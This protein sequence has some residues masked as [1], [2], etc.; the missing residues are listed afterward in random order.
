MKYFL[1]FFFTFNVFAKIELTLLPMDSIV[2]QGEIV[3]TRIQIKDYDGAISLNGVT[4]A[5]T[6]Y[7]YKMSPFIR[8]PEN[9]SM[10][11]EGSIIFLKVPK[12]NEVSGPLQN[13][14]VLVTWK[15]L[16]IQPVQ[17]PESFL[18]G[19][20]Q[21]PK[22]LNVIMI[23][24]LSFI[25]LTLI[26][27]IKRHIHRRKLKSVKIALINQLKDQITSAKDFSEVVNLWK[28]K[29][30]Y[31]ESFPTIEKDFS[32]WEQT[33][34]KYVFKPHITEMEKQLV[35]SSYEDFKTNIGEK[36]RGV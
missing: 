34:F 31:L 3:Q 2:K 19:E 11:T 4:L 24:F 14:E 6:I 1:L 13:Q 26:W 25:S 33:L 36:I 15:D 29:H 35:M 7:F 12:T 8:N 32:D 21:I 16:I 30:Q 27:I 10:Q 18:F 17:A 23:V 20:F 28:M 9:G 22:Q 5:E